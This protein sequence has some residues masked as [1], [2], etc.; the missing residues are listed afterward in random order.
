MQPRQQLTSIGVLALATREQLIMSTLALAEQFIEHGRYLRGWSEKTIRTYRQS[1]AALHAAGVGP[2]TRASLQEFVVRLK[3]RGLTAGGINVRLRSINS[4]LSWLHDE[5]HAAERLR[6]R[7]LPKPVRVLVTFSD[8]EMRRVLA[9]RPAEFA[10][11]RAWTLFV[12][13]TDTGLRIDEALG[14]ERQGVDLDALTL[15]VRGKGDKHRIVPISVEGRKALFRLMSKQSGRYVFTTNTG[16]R[17]NYRNAYRDLKALCRR[18]GVQGS[19]VRPHCVRHYFAVSYVR[20]GGDIYR[21]SRILGHTSISTTQVYLR[22]MGLEHLQEGHA[23][24]S[25]LG[26]LA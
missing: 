3:R 6:V 11:L 25:P 7:L 8:V 5:G 18:A 17:M 16:E 12:T 20:N 10:M 23:K 26:R 21:L 9:L 24:F 19:H 22:S 15:T 4:F 1:L 2:L 14:L 13:L